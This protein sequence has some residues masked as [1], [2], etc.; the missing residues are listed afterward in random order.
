MPLYDATPKWLRA[1]GLKGRDATRLLRALG[2]LA[3]FEGQ[4]KD[5]NRDN[6]A[7]NDVCSAIR[8]LIDMDPIS[9]PSG[10]CNLS[11]CP[12]RQASE[13]GNEKGK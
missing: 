1:H 8:H 11:G 5:A 7:H 6:W 10:A 4:I 13:Q 12:I 3:D 9:G 2:A